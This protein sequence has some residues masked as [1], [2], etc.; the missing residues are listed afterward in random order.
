MAPQW[1]AQQSSG[2]RGALLPDYVPESQRALAGGWGNIWGR[3]APEIS[4]TPIRTATI[5]SGDVQ[6]RTH[7]PGPGRDLCR[8]MSCHHAIMIDVS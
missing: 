3:C 1:Q 7:V 2:A 8:L 6:S 5:M 4:E